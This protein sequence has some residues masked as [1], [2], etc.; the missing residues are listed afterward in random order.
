MRRTLEKK[1]QMREHFAAFLEAMF[2]YGNEEAPALEEDET[3]W[4]LPIFGVYHPLTPGQVG[5][6][7]HC[8]A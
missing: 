6:M 5:V 2:G 3:W 1:L 7:F 8:S 4:H